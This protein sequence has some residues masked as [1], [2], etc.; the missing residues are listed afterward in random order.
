MEYEL[1]TKTLITETDRL[2]TLPRLFGQHHLKF[3]QS[4]YGFMDRFCQG[5]TGGFWLFYKLSNGGFFMALDTD[6]SY[7]VTN[8]A[9]YFDDEM[10]AEAVS[11][12]ANIYAI[13]SLMWDSRIQTPVVNLYDSLRDF[14]CEHPEASK[15]LAFI[16]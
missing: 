1:I 10:S 6:Q 14:A 9:N 7:R 2:G 16:D 5:Y 12:G 13:N 3:E 4:V 11:I 8:P 15:I